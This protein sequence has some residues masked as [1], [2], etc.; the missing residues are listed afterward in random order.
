MLA[1]AVRALPTGPEWSYELKFDGYR[2]LGLK[3]RGQVR[4]GSRNGKDFSR[5]FQQVT[6]ALEALPD[7]TLIDGEIVAVDQ[8]GLP[9]FRLLQDYDASASA[10]LYYAFDLPY[11]RGQDLRGEPLDIRRK[12]LREIVHA[13]P[14]PI[15]YS[16]TFEVP[17]EQLLQVV[18]ERNLEGVV[19]KRR[20]SVYQPGKRSG[21]WVKLRAN[22]REEFVI[23]GYVP[24]VKNFDAILVGCYEDGDLKYTASIR[25]GFTSASRQA[26][27]AGFSK[28]E[29]NSCPFSNLPDVTRGRWGEGITAEV[30]ARC[31]WLQPR[32]VVAV[33]FLEWTP[34]NRLRHASFVELC[35]N[36]HV[37]G[38]RME[39]SQRSSAR[40]TKSP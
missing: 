20:N 25:A 28:L 35:I 38:A 34:A 7:E 1:L 29:A 4:L 36:K 14:D 22:H 10:I 12:M 33:D 21:A 32:L 3:S 8:N 16:E 2:A 27:F 9:R 37:V 5:R 13:L 15:H 11:L 26:L 23:G 30:M 18:R 40:S 24:S 17:V 39:A 19:A 31:R 6:R